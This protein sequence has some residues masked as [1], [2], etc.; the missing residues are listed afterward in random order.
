MLELRPYQ[1]ESLDAINKRLLD[2]IK[3]QVL[4]L[5]TAGGKTIVFSHLIKERQKL[6]KTLILAHREEL[7]NQSKDKLYQVD[8]TITSAIEQAELKTNGEQV[9]I[10]SVATIGRKGSKRLL[11]FSPKEFKTIIIDETH[12]FSL[13]NQSYTNVIRHFGLLKSESEN[14]WNPALLLGVTAT[15]Q[16]ADNA[17]LEKVF[18]EV[19]YNYGIIDAIRDGWLSRI[20]AFRVDTRSSLNSVHTRAGDFAQDELAGVVN[21]PERNDLV[22]K[23]YLEQFNSKQV[24]VYAVNVAHATA[25][26]KA[27]K[28][29]N[30]NCEMVIGTT[31][32]TIRHDILD[33]FEKK[34][35]NV[36]LNVGCLTEG[37]DCATI[38]CI[39]HARP[40]QSGVL[41]RQICGRGMR[42]H[43]DKP[44][45]T[46][47]DFVDNTFRHN[48]Q[49]S[50][51][52]LG[53]EGNVNFRGKD[54]VDSLEQIEK[55]KEM[56][57]TYNLNKLDFDNLDYLMEEV[58]LLAGLEIPQKLREFTSFSWQ[59]HGVSS[60]RINIG[61]NQ[62]FLIEQTI[63][64]QYEVK[65]QTWDSETRKFSVEKLGEINDLKEAI[66]KTDVYIRNNHEDSLKLVKMSAK[67]R[68]EESSE[69]QKF[70]LR[71]LGVNW[72][73]INKLNKGQASLLTSR[74]LGKKKTYV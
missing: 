55:I 52:L 7:L 57:P 46:I 36:L 37:W 50:A 63:T 24:V 2:G 35:I 3:H 13:Q 48:L 39:F 71:K 51:S 62:S 44:Y 59:I 42:L 41:Y 49:T 4:V 40:T 58:D 56:A 14:D 68:E 29:K 67:W 60:Y 9:I 65:M 66:R 5:P 22:V 10:A 16:R 69:K 30:I 61:N 23:T 26:T 17:N 70:L 28:D 54:I 33:L 15:P 64:G 74:I 18:D 34:K 11:K 47:V 32:K 25:L 12:H 20:R 27:F 1:Q 21:N 53:L 19:V 6:G 45:L 72:D 31:E 43:P 73:T 8:P 38:D